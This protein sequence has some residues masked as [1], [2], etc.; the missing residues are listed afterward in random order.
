MSAPFSPQA[1]PGEEISTALALVN[2][3][4]EPRGER[5]DLVPDGPSLAGWLRS[6]GLKTGR[7]PAIADGDL[8]RMRELRAAIRAAFLARAAGRRPPRG[9]LT[10]INA[11]AA[12]VARSPQLAWD[13]NGP[14]QRTR[15]ARAERPV[16]LALAQIAA[17]AIATL[18]DDRGERLRLCQ[19]HGCNRMFIADHRRRRW[20]SRT[21]G[22]RVRVARHHRKVSRGP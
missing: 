17:D 21:C 14:A 10:R 8:D 13:D 3:V 19:A 16:D 20:C 11:A 12:L 9:V 22:D 15:W 7:G 4:V 1:A 18:L 6:R 5:I 2:T